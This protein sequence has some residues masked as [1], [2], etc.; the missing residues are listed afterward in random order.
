[1]AMSTETKARRAAD[2][3]EA[4]RMNKL[5]SIADRVLVTA[6]RNLQTE[7]DGVWIEGDVASFNRII[8]RL[9]YR[10]VRTTSN[11]LNAASRTWCIDANTPSYMDP[12]CESYHSA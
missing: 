10:P 5:V 2:R 12:G 1:M 4:K 8:E 6:E 7:I 9:G 3:A 11:M